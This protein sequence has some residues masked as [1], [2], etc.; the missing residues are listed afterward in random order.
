MKRCPYCAEEIQD[1][2]VKCRYCG[3]DLAPVVVAPVAAAAA[4]QAPAFTHTGQRYVLGYMPDQYA[5]W[6]RAT[7]DE[8]TWRF[9]RTPDGWYRAWNQYRVIEPRAV[10]VPT[11]PLAYPGTLVVPQRTNGMAI[12]SMVLGIVWVYWIGSILA[13]VFGYISLKQIDQSGAQESGR[14]MAIAGIVLGWVGVATLI[15]WIVV[16]AV[17]VNSFT[18]QF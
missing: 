12:A 6:D 13:L 2:A 1:E 5:I 9:D 15:I 16:L 3:S 7:P 17:A 10:A 18:S 11:Q 4:P 14:G 8:P